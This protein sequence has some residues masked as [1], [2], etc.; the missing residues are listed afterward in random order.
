[1]LVLD[2][3]R[4]MYITIDIGGTKTLVARMKKNG[5]IDESIKF[6]TPADYKQF[7][8]ELAENVDKLTT[9]KWDVACVAAPGKIDHDKG[10]AIAFGNLPWKNVPI[11][12]D[13]KKITDCPVLL[14]NDAKLAA[15]SEA[16]LLK[17]P[18][19]K[20][21][22]MTVSTGIGSGTVIDNVINPELQD[23]EV[24]HMLFE[25][26][27]KLVTWESFASGKAI[28][29]RFGKLASEID[30]PE[31]WKIVSRDLAL[32]I[33]DMAANIQPD[34]IIIGGGVGTHFKKYGAFLNDEL[35]KYESPMVPAPKVVGAKNPE[36]AVIYGCYELIKDYEKSVK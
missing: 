22:Y 10:V 14:E 29:R 17:V 13:V 2:D 7:V 5:E 27:G 1:M 8:K 6:P 19:K 11:R 4:A 3:T 35:K 31:I 36:E 33:I 25:R 21:T 15:L 28:V 32:G 30:D 26:N 18:H 9:G 20:V 16:R 34:I 24:G 12:D 23:S